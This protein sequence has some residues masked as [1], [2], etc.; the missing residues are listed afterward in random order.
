MKGNLEV[1]SHDFGG[2]NLLYGIGGRYREAYAHVKMILIPQLWSLQV[3]E[4]QGPRRLGLGFLAYS[5]S[6][7]NCVRFLPE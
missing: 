4:F 5:T 1:V 2:A 6:C 7:I 3:L